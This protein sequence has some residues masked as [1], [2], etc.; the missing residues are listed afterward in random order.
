MEKINIIVLCGGK[1]CES[2][3]S[4][5]T[6]VQT[7][8]ALN[9]D[10]YN[11]Y[12]IYID[13][14]G[15]WWKCENVKDV[16]EI[17]TCN[18]KQVTLN[19]Y[20]NNLYLIKGKKLKLDFTI[21]CAVLALHGGFGENGSIQGLL[22]MCQIPYTSS[23]SISSG[24]TLDKCFTKHILKGN[25][26]KTLPYVI[27]KKY[28]YYE[29]DNK[30]LEKIEKNINFPCIIKPSCLGSSIGI[31][32]ANDKEELKNAIEFAFKFDNKALIEMALKN[33]TE[34]NISAR[35]VNGEIV[36]SEIEKPIK[37]DE[38]LSFND[39]Y[40]YGKKTKLQNI[41]GSK[42]MANT[43]REFP[44]QID[45]A[46][47]DEI[48]N[49]TKKVYEIFDCNGIIRCDYL[50]NDNNEIYLNEINSIPGSLSFYLWN[51]IEFTELLDE[52][53]NTAIKRQLLN[54]DL[55]TKFETSIFN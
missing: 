47:K 5:I 43:K 8:N 18:K 42:G 38:I 19:L 3:I 17:K 52:E 16:K 12:L 36:L 30:M 49:L 34:L 45:K 22:E 31:K 53:I 39:K 21:H 25:K 13:D 10:K 46:I 37:N 6:G 29:N 27:A 48:I 9:T 4:L 35:K 40:I 26:I 7:Y 14:T 50:L 15:K 33:F 44:A 32:I 24:I 55:I 20:E 23:G 11:K 41:Q 28:K 51:K 1:S 2:D 54:A